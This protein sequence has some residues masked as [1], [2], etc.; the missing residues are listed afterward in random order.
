MVLRISLQAV[1]AGKPL[2]IHSRQQRFTSCFTRRVAERYPAVCVPG[3]GVV[4]PWFT[5]GVHERCLLSGHAPGPNS[6]L[7]SHCRISFDPAHQKLDRVKH[8]SRAVRHP[9]ALAN[10]WLARASATSFTF[11]KTRP[12]RPR[13][14][15]AWLTGNNGRAHVRRSTPSQKHHSQCNLCRLC[16][17]GPRCR[18]SGAVSVPG[19]L[20]PTAA[21]LVGT[22]RLPESPSRVGFH[23]SCNSKRGE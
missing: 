1:V 21:H 2:C 4:S 19:R 17:K 3:A 7:L 12:R 9:F 14:W 11:T 22:A 20:V 16:F 8:S 6:T 5:G 10:G 15:S 18:W 23:A 13:C